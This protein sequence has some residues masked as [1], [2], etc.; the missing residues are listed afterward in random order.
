M[1]KIK[2]LIAFLTAF[3]VALV[4][5]CSFSVPAAA[6]EEDMFTFKD[7]YGNT[8]TVDRGCFATRVV[9]FTP[10]SPATKRAGWMITDAVLG[11]PDALVGE[12]EYGEVLTLGGGGVLVVEF[13]SR[14]FDGEG[15]D[16]YV[17]EQGGDVENTYVEVSDN[18]KTW[19]E[20]GEVKGSTAGID[21]NGKVPKGKSFRYVRLTDLRSY[22]RGDWPGADIDAVCAL[23]GTPFEDVPTS[24]S[25][26]DAVFWAVENGITS[27]TGTGTFSPENPCTRYQFAVMI[28]KL[29]GRPAAPDTELPFMDVPKNASYYNA[30]NWAYSKGIIAGT[31]PTTFSP[32]DSITR[33]QA[34]KMLYKMVGQPSVPGSSYNPFKDVSKTDSFYKAVLWAVNNNITKGTSDT[35]FSPY[36]TCL[37]YQLVVFLYKFN[38][39]YH[40][41]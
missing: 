30:V 22:A 24:A 1:K 23:C 38:K 5:L 4:S 13:A 19:Y 6:A 7:R 14:I 41:K 37:R 12:A 39:L 26:Y 20:I 3:T 21:I 18:L 36:G 16:I 27:G 8:V 29:A 32:N 10:G 9:S 11:V 25:Y 15:N 17:F 40:F 31:S 28:Y 35:K 33:Y 34:V 2:T